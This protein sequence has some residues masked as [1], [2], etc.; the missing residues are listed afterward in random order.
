MKRAN[1]LLATLLCLLLLALPIE[2]LRIRG[3]RPQPPVPEEGKLAASLFANFTEVPGMPGVFEYHAWKNSSWMVEDISWSLHQ[4]F[5]TSY[6]GKPYHVEA[7]WSIHVSREV[8]EASAYLVLVL[9]DNDTSLR[10]FLRREGSFNFTGDEVLTGT[11][12]IVANINVTYDVSVR[13]VWSNGT[14]VVQTPN[15]T[16]PRHPLFPY[17]L[18]VTKS[19]SYSYA[20]VSYD[21]VQI[22]FLDVSLTPGEFLSLR[23][24]MI[25]YH[26]IAIKLFKDSNGNGVMDFEVAYDPATKRYYLTNESEEIY[27]FALE[28]ARLAGVEAPHVEN[29][30][31]LTWALRV[32][33][34]KGLLIPSGVSTWAVRQG[35]VNV[36]TYDE[37]I[38]EFGAVF[39]FS[40]QTRGNYSV[41]SLKVDTVIGEWSNKTTVEGLGLCFLYLCRHTTIGIERT[42]S[43]VNEK[44]EEVSPEQNSTSLTSLCF[45]SGEEIVGNI[46]LGGPKYR[47]NETSYET[48]YAEL[49]P[50]RAFN[51]TYGR[52]GLEG[53]VLVEVEREMYLYAVC[54]P[55]WSGW[56][57]QHDPEFSMVA[58][59]VTLAPAPTVAPAWYEKPAVAAAIIAV[60]V[61][62]AVISIIILRRKKKTPS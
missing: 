57:I 40:P 8:A 19:G 12:F 41:A 4:S 44:G 34:I 36:T 55:K 50:I 42:L 17:T 27:H 54:Y 62:V 53:G 23:A 48:A 14:H 29:G 5:D 21:I 24:E 46:T 32:E 9:W 56:K 43:T 15:I 18:N 30:N 60:V 59:T 10:P 58:G 11:L 22:K 38:S 49:V 13:N 25:R 39:R 52:I 7:D 28:R 51:L 31:T 2:A 61:A 35:R 37:E 26:A 20:W 16:D 6:N 47:W 1:L 33:G 45:R 3:W